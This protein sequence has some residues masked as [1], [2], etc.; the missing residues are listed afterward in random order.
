VLNQ[1]GILVKLHVLERFFNLVFGQV[2][3]LSFL[4]AVSDAW[5]HTGKLFEHEQLTP[6]LV[7]KPR[8]SNPNFLSSLEINS[9]VNLLNFGFL[10]FVHLL[11]KKDKSVSL[12]KN[13]QLI[14]WIDYH[15][16]VRHC[17]EEE[18]DENGHHVCDASHIS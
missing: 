13:K 16:E 8:F 3:Q 18:T 2:Q 14:E 6:M 9:K 7:T 17:K 5:F 15:G 1:P 12:I 10:E 11:V 4:F